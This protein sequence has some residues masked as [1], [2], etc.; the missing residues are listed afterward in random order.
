[1]RFREQTGDG[2]LPPTSNDDH[3]RDTPFTELLP[4]SLPRISRLS[5]APRDVHDHPAGDRVPSPLPERQSPDAAVDCASR[6]SIPQRIGKT[7][8]RR[9]FMPSSFLPSNLSSRAGWTPAC[10]AP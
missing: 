5:D 9:L 3:S 4:T 2:T 8:N 10:T 6:A 1:M 7:A